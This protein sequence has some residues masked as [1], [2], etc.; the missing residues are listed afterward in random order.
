[1]SDLVTKFL[2][3]RENFTKW[4]NSFFF[5]D[6]WNLLSHRFPTI[7]RVVAT[8]EELEERMCLIPGPNQLRE[9]KTLWAFVIRACNCLPHKICSVFLRLLSEKSFGVKWKIYNR[10]S[11]TFYQPL[12]KLLCLMCAKTLCDPCAAF[13]IQKTSYVGPKLQIKPN[14]SVSNGSKFSS[15]LTDKIFFQLWR[16]NSQIHNHA[17]WYFSENA[18]RFSHTLS[19]WEALFSSHILSK[20]GDQKGNTFSIWCPQH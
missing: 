2:A 12:F 9:Y 15:N 14:K 3:N 11:A 10:S 4:L 20:C 7:V 16:A 1:M 18:Q 19:T 5:Q 13:K 17:A 6:G 8:H